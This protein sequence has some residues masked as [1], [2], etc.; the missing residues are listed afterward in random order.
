MY[1]SST[2]RGFVVVALVVVVLVVLVVVVVGRV[3]RCVGRSRVL[4][5]KEVRV[6]RP[7]K[8][9]AVVGFCDC[10]CGWDCDCDWSTVVG[11][12]VVL[13]VVAG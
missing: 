12:V 7:M 9:V 6:T 1:A 4:A 10:D 5:F 13:V 3:V 8:V 2:V 11:V